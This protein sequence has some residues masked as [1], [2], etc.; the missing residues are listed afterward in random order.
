MS[1]TPVDILHTQFKSAF[2]GYNTEQVD[3]FVD[4]VGQA[5]EAALKEKADL[6][7]RIESLEEEI[8][9]VR[10]IKSTLADALA[11]AQRNADEL[12][13]N[14][15][16][17]AELIIAEAEQA[18]VK[19]MADV[20]AEAEKLRAEVSLLQAQRDR[21]EAEFRAMLASYT[22]WL[23]RRGRDELVRSEVA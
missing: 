23:D 5:L 21:F 13:A 17:Q 2:R 7:R 4:A 14:A 22:E 15:H 10:K 6:V 11:V 18:R 12:R 16:K 8:D 3:D 20:Q 9:E 19:L 1:L